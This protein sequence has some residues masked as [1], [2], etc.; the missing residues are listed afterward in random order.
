MS[1]KET[2]PISSTTNWRYFLIP[3]AFVFLLWLFTMGSFTF[4]SDIIPYDFGDRGT[5]GDMFGGLNA[6]FTG[7]AFAGVIYTMILQREDLKQQMEELKLTRQI[8]ADQQQEM[9]AQ[10][11]TLAI[12]R[13]ENSFFSLLNFYDQTI[14]NMAYHYLSSSTGTIKTIKVT[15]LEV[16]K[17]FLTKLHNKREEHDFFDA[18]DMIYNE[19][20]SSLLRYI[21][22]LYAIMSFVNDSKINDKQKYFNIINAAL[23]PQEKVFIYFV[24]ST[25]F[26]L[27]DDFEEIIK[28]YKVLKGL[29]P[30]DFLKQ[31]D[32]L[33]GEL[34]GIED[35]I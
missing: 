9:A 6:L 29:N 22:T 27:P 15:G 18:Y 3:V 33:S 8:L 11:T 26:L 13:F 31:P 5:F 4:L 30:G 20:K 32:A 1:Q 34:S 28:D 16:I 10:N 19:Y 24:L 14:S 35:Y 17:N 7:L 23:G 2:K 12:Q 25:D 21:N